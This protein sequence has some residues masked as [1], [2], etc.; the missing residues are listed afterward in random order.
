MLQLR[1]KNPAATRHGFDVN[2][3]VLTSARATSRRWYDCAASLV[4]FAV[5]FV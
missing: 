2:V 3:P 4:F 1:R 5:S